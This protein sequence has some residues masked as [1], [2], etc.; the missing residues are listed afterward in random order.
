[1]PQ[2]G[3]FA[4]FLFSFFSISEFPRTYLRGSGGVVA[5]LAPRERARL[6]QGLGGLGGVFAEAAARALGGIVTPEV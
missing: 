1:M 4:G 2:S 3:N 5:G 6:E